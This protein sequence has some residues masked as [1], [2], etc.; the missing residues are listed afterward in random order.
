[1][2][3]AFAKRFAVLSLGILALC[4]Q[5]PGPGASAQDGARSDDPSFITLGAGY[6][7]FNARDDAAADFRL[8]YRHG[9]KLWIFKPWAG[10]EFTS[11]GAAYGLAGVLVD[12]YFGRRLVVTPSFGAGLYHDG[13]GK[14]LGS[15]I[16]FRSQVEMSYRFN[17]RS[18]IGI[19]LSHISNAGI[20]QRNPGTEILN[21][22]YS[23]PFEK[24]FPPSP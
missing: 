4:L 2:I 21:V 16:E 18:R 10:F 24:I 9:R 23:I 5:P 7:D 3:G 8:E 19:A 22:Y 20:T 1:M 6:Y 14:D 17:D 12:V 13:D 15:L 11:D